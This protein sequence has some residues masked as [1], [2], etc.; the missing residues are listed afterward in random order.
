MKNIIAPS[1]IVGQSTAAQGCWFAVLDQ[2][3]AQR[4][5]WPEKWCD[6]IGAHA[7]SA[8]R[9]LAADAP[10]TLYAACNALLKNRY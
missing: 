9:A 5:D 10:L 4:L 3:A 2:G 1:C 6:A 8:R 7:Q